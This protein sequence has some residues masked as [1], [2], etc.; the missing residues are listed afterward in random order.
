[1]NDSAPRQQNLQIGGLGTGRNKLPALTVALGGR[2]SYL[3]A[4]DLLLKVTPPRVQRQ[5]PPRESM[6]IEGPRLQDIRTLLVQAPPGFGKT[7]LLAQWRLD[8][9]G[10]GVAVAWVTGQPEDDEQRLLQSLALAVRTGTGRPAFGQELLEGWEGTPLEGITRWLAQLVQSALNV[11]LMI[12]DADRM[13]PGS[14]VLLTYLLRNQPPNL[15][16]V[17]GAR[18]DCDLEL[19]GLLSYGRALQ[20]GPTDLRVSLDETLTLVRDRIGPDFDADM[21]GRLHEFCEGWPLGLQLLLTALSIGADPRDVLQSLEGRGQPGTSGPRQQLMEL[22]FSGLS[23]A[24]M[25]LLES[26]AVADQLHPDLCRAISGADDAGAQLQ[27]L[28][29]DTPLLTRSEQG[30]W[31]Q[32]HALARDFLRERLRQQRS[33][34]EVAELHRRAAAWF[35]GTD[36]LETAAHHAWEAGQTAEAL[37]LAERSLYEALAMRGRQSMVHEWLLRLPEKERQRSPRLQLACAWALALSED[38]EAAADIVAPLL[39]RPNASPGL[40][41]EC[42]LILS[43]AAIFADEPDRFA[44]LHDRWAPASAL[45]DP[46]LLQV[47]ANRSALRLVLEGAP[48]LA[49]QRLHQQQAAQPQAPAAT[50]FITQWSDLIEGLSYL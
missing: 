29:R 42:A 5:W 43:G 4:L 21:V 6:L 11:V 40:R 1:L 10:R 34:A 18:S 32:L 7:S 15:R 19:D 44:A 14:R 41:C 37:D 46:L 28:L 17:V 49:R 13:P 45:Q 33:P 31:L 9:L 27:R 24:D 2:R 30:E 36:M 38:H 23:D 8:L 48:A 35:R 20:L 22:L 39:A 47:H 25:Q 16:V 26:I 3:P 50:R 12:D